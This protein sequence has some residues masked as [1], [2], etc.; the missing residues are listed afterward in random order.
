MLLLLP[1]LCWQCAQQGSP[2]GGPKDEAPPVVVECN[3]P[4]YSTRF[5][6]VKIEITFDEYIVL[7]NVNQELV[8]SP[9]MQEKPEVKL[10][11]KTLV[12]QFMEELK[13]STTYT[14]N[15]GSAIK[16]LHE[17]NK[18]LNYEYVFST[19]EVLDSLSVKG[20]LLYA[21]DL[22]KPDESISILL[23]DDTRDSV[24]L[25]DIPLYVGRSNDSGVFSV[26]NLKDG[27]Y[28]VFALKDGNYNTLFDLPT[29]EIAFLD[30][31]L[32]LNAKFIRNLMEAAAREDSMIVAD[33]INVIVADTLTADSLGVQGPDYTSIFIDMLL[34]TEEQEI[35]YLTND[36]RDDRRMI[37]MIF[38]RPLTDSFSY[39]VLG[40]EVE[41]LE[42]FT[43]N[44]D[45][46]SLWIRD[47]LDYK[48][49]TLIMELRYTVRDTVPGYVT[50]TDTLRFI[51]REKSSKNKKD[52]KAKEAEKLTIST[53]RANG[54]QHLNRDLR[55]DFNVPLLSASDSLIRFYH[56]PDTVDLPMEYSYSADTLMPT[57]AW[58][59]ARWESASR[60]RLVMLPGAIQSIYDLKHDT[61]DVTFKTT[62]EEYYGRILLQLTG[63]HDEV[64]LQLMKK[65][66]MVRKL[67]VNKDGEYEFSFLTP[68]DYSLK[69]IHDL[70]G[71][72][73]WDTGKYLEKRQ[74]E[75]V[76]FLPKEINVRSNWDHDVTMSLKK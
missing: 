55:L 7:D 14:L 58:I 32:I 20:T 52:N 19:G 8:V 40:E 9:P 45:T 36:T 72:G 59:K 25:L 67:T 13:D 41:M 42:Y 23:Y 35:Q 11:K 75:P 65:G 70:N 12:I 61:V 62:D 76:E 53:I 37:Q 44:R 17:G 3:P 22:S 5:D 2:T 48:K 74:P 71:N 69:F 16:D 46:L 66:N 34:F 31:T 26:N 63:V 54:E 57:R 10:K 4:N 56:V 27:E 51:Y 64:I 43:P 49:D 24:P 60:Y 47:S 30:T 18:L 50:Q 73:K 68:G 21:E 28:K 39:R 33:T 15:F 1:A 29:E 6:A 38:A